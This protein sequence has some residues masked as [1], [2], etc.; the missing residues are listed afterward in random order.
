MI[1][2]ERK[3]FIPQDA[4]YSQPYWLEEG[5]HKDIYIVEDQ[6]LIGQPKTDY[7]LY[8]TFNDRTIRN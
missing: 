4:N 6:N 5:N 3:I 8:A 2:V 7:P 1:S